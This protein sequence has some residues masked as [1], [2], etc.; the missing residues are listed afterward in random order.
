MDLDN[1]YV[2][3]TCIHDELRTPAGVQNVLIWAPVTALALQ[4]AK[5]HDMATQYLAT[6]AFMTRNWV[7]RVACLPPARPLF[8]HVCCV[9][10]MQAFAKTVG[11]RIDTQLS[12]PLTNLKALQLY[13]Q[14][15]L[16]AIEVHGA[17]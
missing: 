1:S 13:Y 4:Q 9:C 8:A 11:D 15:L 12:H 14:I 3:F 10:D 2:C 7:V 6:E 5:V 16:D 17:M